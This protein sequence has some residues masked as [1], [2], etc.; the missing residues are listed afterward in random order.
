MHQHNIQASD[1][2]SLGKEIGNVYKGYGFKGT[3]LNNIEE[4][5]KKEQYDCYTKYFP[6]FLDI[7]EGFSE[8]LNLPKEYI[9]DNHIVSY[10]NSVIKRKGKSSCSALAINLD[11]PTVFRNYDW[12]EKARKEFSIFNI[13][14]NNRKIEIFSD[15]DITINTKEPSEYYFVPV[16]G[17][18]GDIFIS[19]NAAPDHK[20][21][22]GIYAIHLLLKVVLQAQTTSEAIEIIKN[23]PSADNKIYII[24]DKEGNL[25][26]VEGSK[27]GTWVTESKEYI[28]ATNHYQSIEGYRHNLEVLKYIPFHSTYVRAQTLE[29]NLKLGMKDKQDIKKLFV[30]PP[31]FQNWK[32]EVNGDTVTVYTHIYN[33]EDSEIIEH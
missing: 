22:T 2:R 29:M 17:S 21:T 32:G 23:T 6:E 13:D 1:Y 5:I 8:S 14:F 4:N 20:M 24:A 30:N 26:R 7:L 31:L 9:F 18:N 28:Y 16:E 27:D 33:F 10:V 15:N 12:S 3:E 25:A 19:L 11:K